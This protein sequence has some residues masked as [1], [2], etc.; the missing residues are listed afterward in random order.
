[1][2]VFFGQI[3]HF[4]RNYAESNLKIGDFIYSLQANLLN[5]DERG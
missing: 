4:F 3:A 5:S 2:N 1:M